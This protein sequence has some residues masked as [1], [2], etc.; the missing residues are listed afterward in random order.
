MFATFEILQICLVFFFA[1]LVKGILGLGLPTISLTLLTVI[2]DLPSAMVLMLLPSFITNLWQAIEGESVTAVVKRHGIFFFFATV[3]ISIGSFLLVGQST[4]LLPG[5][6][7][8]LLVMYAISGIAGKSLKLTASSKGIASI[9]GMVN[10]LLTGM[11]GSFVVP[12]VFYLQS[13]GL[14]RDAMVQA[15]GV[16]FTLSTLALLLSLQGHQL[17]ALST[18]LVSLTG[19]IPALL[20]MRIGRLTRQHISAV[21]FKQIFY[22]ALL[23]SGGYFIVKT[24]IGI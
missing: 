1:G 10:G 2:F 19:V 6:L 15:M 16:L 21:R 5:L 9:F 11:T 23:V 8:L 24:S 20:G 13:I 14:S 7:G 17:I 12:G 3:S 4:Q 18:A 22:L